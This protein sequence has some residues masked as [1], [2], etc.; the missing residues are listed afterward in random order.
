MNGLSEDVLRR[1]MSAIVAGKTSGQIVRELCV[2]HRTVARVRRRM[3]ERRAGNIILDPAVRCGS[4]GALVLLSA[5]F[6][7]ACW[8]RRTRTARP[9]DQVAT[10]D[11]R[12]PLLDV[13]AASL[14]EVVAGPLAGALARVL[15]S[16]D[17]HVVVEL[18]EEHSRA[19]AGHR[20]RV[21]TRSVTAVPTPAQIRRRA[22]ACRRR[23]LAARSGDIAQALRAVRR[24]VSGGSSCHAACRQAAIDHGVSLSTLY[25]RARDEDVRTACRPSRAIEMSPR[26]NRNVTAAR[27][28]LAARQ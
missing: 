25:A 6:C 22:A 3:K 19:P 9:R 18:L 4:C 8:L 20:A 5:G 21:N 1:V 12:E 24:L 11:V 27:E 13:A 2:C 26:R 17:S 7:R 15:E 14:V 23:A 10:T 16:S 28:H